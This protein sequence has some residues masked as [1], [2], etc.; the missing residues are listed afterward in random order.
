M[1][2]SETLRDELKSALFG[3]RVYIG[4]A[5]NIIGLDE[6]TDEDLIAEYTDYLGEEEDDLIK[7]CIAEMEMDNLLNA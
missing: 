3:I 5:D 1:P 4:G 2:L 6:M 7:R